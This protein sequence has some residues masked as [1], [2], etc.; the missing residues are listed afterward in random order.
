MAARLERAVEHCTAGTL[1]GRIE[2]VH[3]RMRRTGPT[4]VPVANDGSI[5][6]GDHGADHGIGAGAAAAALGEV[7]CSLQ[8]RPIAGVYHD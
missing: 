4:M 8:E 1:A 6:R 7:K 5:H 3:L 2:R